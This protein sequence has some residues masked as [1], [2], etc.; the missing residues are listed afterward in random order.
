MGTE[1]DLL[2]NYPKT[3]R[4]LD[5]RLESKTE[6]DRAIARKFGKDF[7]MVTEDMAMVDLP[8]IRGFGASSPNFYRTLGSY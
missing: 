7:L 5:A 6:L 3:P 2:A 4:D 1:I 8:T